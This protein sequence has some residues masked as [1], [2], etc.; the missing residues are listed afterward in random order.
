[1]NSAFSYENLCNKLSHL[2]GNPRSNTERSTR[3]LR[4]KQPVHFIITLH[5]IF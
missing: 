3:Y 1:M 4:K 2:H 5:I